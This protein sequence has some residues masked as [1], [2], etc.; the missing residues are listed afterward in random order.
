MPWKVSIYQHVQ[1]LHQFANTIV[2]ERRRQIMQT[3]KNNQDLLSRFMVSH[4]E[5]GELLNNQEL[6]DIILNFIIAGRD[7][8]AQSLSWTFYMILLNPHVEETLLYEINRTISDDLI[9]KPELLYDAVKHMKYAHAMYVKT[10]EKEVSS[11]VLILIV[12]LDFLK[13]CDCIQ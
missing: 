1:T 8:T 9:E 5:K 13:H 6:R 11:P 7:T 4:N 12:F 3:R 10:I 2:D